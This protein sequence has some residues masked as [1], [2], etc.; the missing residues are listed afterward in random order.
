[1]FI[2]LRRVKHLLQSRQAWDS[3][4]RACVGANTSLV[5]AII[6]TCYMWYISR[7]YWNDGGRLSPIPPTL[8]GGTTSPA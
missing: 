6:V 4:S 8:S 5:L 2:K 1:M 7:P 3:S